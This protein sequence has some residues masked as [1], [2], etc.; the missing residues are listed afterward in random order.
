MGTT[1]EIG[2]DPRTMEDN[3]Q[4]Y[5]YILLLLVSASFTEP[6]PPR[7]DPKR[8]DRG[9]ATDDI[10]RRAEVRRTAPL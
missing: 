9:E 3:L 6:T 2:G 4:D 1:Q 7:R 5:A 10:R 8:S